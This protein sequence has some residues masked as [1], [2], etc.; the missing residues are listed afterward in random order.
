M[1]YRNY[2]TA[3]GLIVDPS[4]NG[5]FKTIGAALTAAVSGDTIFIRPSTYTENPTLKAGV[6][7]VTY[8][9]IGGQ[10]NAATS[11]GN[12]IIEGKCTFTGA[13]TVVLTGIT[14][15]TNSDYCL[16]VTGSVA[17]IVYLNN[18][19]INAL[20]NTAIQ[21]TSSSATSGI[22][23]N[24]C[25]GNL[26]TATGTLFTMSSPG[27]LE[28]NWTEIFNGGTLTTTLSTL[29][30]GTFQPN[31][32][33][34]WF[35]LSTSS[36]GLMFAKYT[37]FSTSAGTIITTAG[38]GASVFFH[39]NFITN[40][41]NADIT[42]GTGTSVSLWDC[43]LNSGATYPINGTGTLF[44]SDIQFNSIC[45]IDPGLTISNA[46]A[47]TW[48]S[49]GGIG[50]TGQVWTSNGASSPPTFQTAS[51]GVVVQQVRANTST[52]SNGAT[53]FALGATPTTSGGT[54]VLSVAITPTNAAH[55]LVI[56]YDYFVSVNNGTPTTAA[57]VI[58]ALFNGGSN[59][60]YAQI[61]LETKEAAGSAASYYTNKVTGKFYMTAGTTSATTFTVR[62]GMYGTAASWYFLEDVA[63]STLNGVQF[64]SI[65]VTEYTA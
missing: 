34:L 45:A 27:N 1:G 51:G 3:N 24:Y 48:I 44:F 41:S 37:D 8:S 23:L 62:I 30:A 26:A 49:G 10:Y 29:S 39:C 55:V 32:S 15:Q 53:T 65:I 42:I 59:A 57:G 43:F 38:T 47:H 56:E 21:Y 28:T 14:L 52:Q 18:C 20:N 35:P 58:S 4:G 60:I 5:D 11:I 46:A 40:N 36:S 64:A 54:Q 61:D 50:T 31:F 13:G 63:T 9:A 6:N 19:F 16:S 12:V 25:Q 2:S 33:K 17:S 22:F 7:L